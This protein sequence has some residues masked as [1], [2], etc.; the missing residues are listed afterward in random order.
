MADHLK[1]SVFISQAF[2]Q[3]VIWS[4]VF[5]NFPNVIKFSFASALQNATEN[6]LD[7]KF[8]S[9]YPLMTFSPHR[10]LRQVCENAYTNTAIK[11]KE[12]TP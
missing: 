8:A 10:T 9:S 1:I 2:G 6:N 11:R 5:K 4:V 12:Q 3:I 7:S